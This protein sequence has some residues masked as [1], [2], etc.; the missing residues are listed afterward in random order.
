M[1]DLVK[2]ALDIMAREGGSLT[3]GRWQAGRRWKDELQKL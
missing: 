3:R 1:Q 2:E